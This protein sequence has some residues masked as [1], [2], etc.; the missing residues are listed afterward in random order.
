MLHTGY[1]GIQAFAFRAGVFLRFLIR[2]AGLWIIDALAGGIFV[3]RCFSLI[4]QTRLHRID[5]TAGC[6]A[7]YSFR[8]QQLFKHIDAGLLGLYDLTLLVNQLALLFELLLQGYKGGGQFNTIGQ[9]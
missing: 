7:F 5:F 1:I 9:R 3:E 8:T 6:E 4:E 2:L